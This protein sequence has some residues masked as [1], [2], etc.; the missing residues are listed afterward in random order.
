M[1]TTAVAKVLQRRTMREESFDSIHVR[2]LSKMII[3]YNAKCLKSSEIS[4]DTTGDETS[5]ADELEEETSEPKL[6]T[7]RDVREAVHPLQATADRVGRQVELFAETLDRLAQRDQP[8]TDD[9]RRVLPLVC[10]FEKVSLDTVK[11]LAKDHSSERIERLKDTWRQRLRRT[12][13]VRSRSSSR[14][15][16]EKRLGDTS[17]EDL[18]DWDEEYQTWK[19]FRL[20]LQTQ[21]PVKDRTPALPNQEERYHRPDSDKRIHQ[22]SSEQD[23]WA[24]F[25]GDFD[26]VWEKNLVVEWLK[27]SANGTAKDVGQVIE[28]V[29]R[30]GQEGGQLSA[31]G[32]LD[33]REA[34]KK[35]KRLRS[36]PQPLEPGSPGLDSSH[37]NKD[38]TKRLVTQLDPD[39]VSRQ[40]RGLE[41]G[42]VGSERTTWLGCWELLR[43][44][45]SWDKIRDFCQEREQGW[46][47][48][49]IRGDPRLASAGSNKRDAVQQFQSR[50][51][52]RNMCLR[53]AKGGGLDEYECAVYG[54]LCGDLES[55]EAVVKSWDDYLFALYNSQLLNQFDFYI[56]KKLSNR[57]P[58]TVDP[59]SRQLLLIETRPPNLS[60]EEAWQSLLTFEATR[61]EA[62]EPMKMLQGSLIAGSAPRYLREQG[63]ALATT[64]QEPIGDED[65]NFLRILAHMV[66]VFVQLGSIEFGDPP[67]TNI[68]SAYI[69]FLGHA[70]KLDLLPLYASCLTL[71]AAIDSLARQLPKIVDSGERQRFIRLASK[72]DIEPVQILRQQLI[73]LA[74]TAQSDPNTS[75]F[76]KLDMLEFP[77]PGSYEVPKIK[78]GFMSDE[79]TEQQVDLI[80]GVEWYLLLEHQWPE[81]MWAGALV[82][83][84]FL[85]KSRSPCSLFKADTKY[86][87]SERSLCSGKRTD[88]T[89]VFLVCF[90]REN[91]I[92][93]RPQDGP[94]CGAA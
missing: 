8:D 86:A 34:I 6:M 72:Y 65:Y 14:K 56:Q 53:A 31:S 19:L 38:R 83:K 63:F 49:S 27:D 66:L 10:G 59:K 47:A 42:E 44:G 29:E 36:W 67:T 1:R 25:L 15:G 33:S 21:Y 30:E 7:L 13:G 71:R 82:H 81:T 91:R 89:G 93:L 55:S 20:M 58:Q 79:L 11:S 35:Q 3:L 76:P 51:L 48:L 16:S 40:D 12:S 80:H 52:W 32:W 57:L 88:A 24:S 74:Q 73:H 62:R 68:V 23:I 54:L 46:Q 50:S 39:A 90:A 85:R 75:D 4:N 2:N 64:A 17:V 22:Y 28:E 37:V 9:C 70:G 84:F 5:T 78:A 60:G 45:E 18:Q 69:D 41:L 87:N 77:Q 94:C 43:R 61:E 26:D 92:S